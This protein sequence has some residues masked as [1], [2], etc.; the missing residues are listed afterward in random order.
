MLPKIDLPDQL[1]E[2][3]SW[4]GFLD[5]FVQLPMHCTAQ[6]C[7]PPRSSL[8]RSRNSSRELPS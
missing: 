6:A 1:S 4:T 7:S 5:A 8:L 3:D 2:V